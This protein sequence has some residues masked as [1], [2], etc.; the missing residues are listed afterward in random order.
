[1]AGHSQ[2]AIQDHKLKI[3]AICSTLLWVLPLANKSIGFYRFDSIRLK[4]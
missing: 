1:M 4:F 3:V 2:L